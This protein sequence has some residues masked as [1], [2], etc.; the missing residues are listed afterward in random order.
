M[1]TGM[2]AV[3]N[4]VR[5]ERHD[6]LRANTDQEYQEEALHRE[7]IPQLGRRWPAPSPSSTA[8]LLESVSG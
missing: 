4:S 3:R 5:G 7:E 1:L 6:L 2:L 8:S